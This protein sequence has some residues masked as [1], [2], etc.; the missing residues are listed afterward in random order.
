ME[1]LRHWSILCSIKME[2]PLGLNW[3]LGAFP[4]PF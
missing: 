3:L 4:I 2:T 1:K